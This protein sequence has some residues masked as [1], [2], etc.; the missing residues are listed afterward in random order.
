MKT[1]NSKGHVWILVGLDSFV[2]LNDDRE[3]WW[4]TTREKAREY[5]AIEVHWGHKIKGPILIKY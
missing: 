5:K 1:N 4:F 3:V 2:H